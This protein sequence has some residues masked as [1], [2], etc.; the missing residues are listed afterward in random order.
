MLQK[1]RIGRTLGAQAEAAAQ[2]EK[3]KMKLSNYVVSI[4][5]VCL[6]LLVVRLT[7]SDSEHPGAKRTAYWMG[8]GS[9]ILGV[10]IALCIF[11]EGAVMLMFLIGMPAFIFTLCFGLLGLRDYLRF[12]HMAE[13]VYL[14][15]GNIKVNHRGERRAHLLL[16]YQIQDKTY[17]KESNDD[18]PVEWIEQ[19]LQPQQ[20]Y[21]VWVDYHG[22]KGD[23]RL[24]RKAGLGAAV[25][26]LLFAAGIGAA[27][28]LGMRSLFL[29][30]M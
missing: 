15:M 27:V 12:S 13:G 25:L 28:V 29:S 2:K 30:A 20:T 16:Q 10:S 9:L 6:G 24:N 26:L 11:F 3:D 8:W 4:V 21:P 5:L 7:A 18:Y 23:V 22:P 19:N 1:E 17:Q 14:E